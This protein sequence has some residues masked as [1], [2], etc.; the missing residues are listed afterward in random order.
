MRFASALMILLVLGPVQAKTRASAPDVTSLA[1]MAGHWV[2]TQ[3][4]DLSE[5]IWLPPASDAMAGMWR[6]GSKGQIRLYELLT[7]SEE[8][9]RV[10]LRLR[11]FRP[12]L[13]ALEDRDSPLVLP[14][15]RTGANEAV[16][17]GTGSDGGRLRIIYRRP[18]PDTLEAAVEKGGKSQQFTYRRRQ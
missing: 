5:E 14:L 18:S 12:N 15:I 17:E 11:H 13:A 6:W 4:E 7:I 10:V 9:D 1:W 2:G 16:F 3:T 8:G